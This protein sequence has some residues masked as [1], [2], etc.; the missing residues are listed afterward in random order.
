MKIQ[1]LKIQLHP[2]LMFLMVNVSQKE[3]NK[4]SWQGMESQHL[5]QRTGW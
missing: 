1:V 4:A 5:A 3:E 2:M